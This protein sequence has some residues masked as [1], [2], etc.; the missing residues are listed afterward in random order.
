MEVQAGSIPESHTTLS[1]VLSGEQRELCSGLRVAV[2]PAIDSLR[3]ERGCLPKPRGR[4]LAELRDVVGRVVDR[5]R[6]PGRQVAFIQAQEQAVL[7]RQS[8]CLS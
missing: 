7:V 6:D 8:V 3:E 1:D 5:V 4:V 2:D